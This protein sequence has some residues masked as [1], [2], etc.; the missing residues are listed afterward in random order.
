VIDKTTYFVP[1]MAR[2]E[3]VELLRRQGE[4]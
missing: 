3:Q 1:T 2:D 4:R